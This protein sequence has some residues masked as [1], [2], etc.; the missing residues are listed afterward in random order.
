MTRDE[1]ERWRG[2]DTEA[3]L[4]FRA[5]LDRAR[6]AG[7][8]NDGHF[9]IGVLRAALP[10][11]LHRAEV[12]AHAAGLAQ[13][14]A[15]MRETLIDLAREFRMEA[16]MSWDGTQDG[17]LRSCHMGT[18]RDIVERRIRAL[19]DTSEENERG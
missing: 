14:R 4:A 1:I 8:P 5:A 16:E 6:D 9:M 15:E 17:A 11:V 18:A 10:G 12:A 3:R 13:G 2:A 19:P 7:W